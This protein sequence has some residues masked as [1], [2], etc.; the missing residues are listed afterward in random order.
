MQ[1][2]KVRRSTG[3]ITTCQ[4]YRHLATEINGF[5]DLGRFEFGSVYF[6]LRLLS[7]C[8]LCRVTATCWGRCLWCYTRNEEF[9]F[10]IAHFNGGSA[11]WIF[12]NAQIMKR[13]LPLPLLAIVTRLNLVPLYRCRTWFCRFKIVYWYRDFVTDLHVLTKGYQLCFRAA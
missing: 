5:P 4:T 3:L 2:D 11:R 7:F 13:T 6:F 8:R 12:V 9:T 10:D 1:S